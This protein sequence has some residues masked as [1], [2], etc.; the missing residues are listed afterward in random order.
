[1]ICTRHTDCYKKLENNVQGGTMI[2]Q[3]E[4]TQRRQQIIGF[5]NMFT[6]FD[7][8][9]RQL[10]RHLDLCLNMLEQ[11]GKGHSNTMRP[12]PRQFSR[13]GV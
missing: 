12:S 10:S 13:H 9:L 2:N 11:P 6:H 8:S 7:I 3:I 5:D 1:M 4:K